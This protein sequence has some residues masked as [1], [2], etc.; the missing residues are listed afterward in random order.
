MGLF[1]KKMDNDGERRRRPRIKCAVVTRLTDNRGAAWSCK[2]IDF[3]E[4][5]LCISTSASLNAGNI[6]NVSR[7][8]IEAKVIWSTDNRAGLTIVR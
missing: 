6:I 8:A 3:S 7:P 4:K 5:G 2:I 1:T